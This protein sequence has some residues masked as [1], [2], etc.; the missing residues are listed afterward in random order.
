MLKAR[1][2]WESV[3]SSDNFKS[4]LYLSI[5]VMNMLLAVLPDKVQKV[6]EESGCVG[7]R[8][9][10]ATYLMQAIDVPGVQQTLAR[11]CVLDMDFVVDQ[12]FNGAMPKDLVDSCQSQLQNKHAKVS[13]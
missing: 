13:V 2:N 3:A 5:G 11:I 1:K 4:G 10:G 7:D 8:E 12:S 6:L 9:L